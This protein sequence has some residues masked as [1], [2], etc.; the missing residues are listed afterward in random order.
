MTGSAEV[1]WTIYAIRK[2]ESVDWLLRSCTQLGSQKVSHMGYPHT[3]EKRQNVFWGVFPHVWEIYLLVTTLCK[4]NKIKK[5]VIFPKL[6]AKYKI[7]HASQQTA[8]GVYFPKWGHL[9]GGLC[10]LGILGP[11]KLWQVVQRWH[12]QFTPLE[13][14]GVLIGFRGPVHS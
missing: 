3:Q 5:I 10:Y 13:N 9:G 14:L 1:T 6:V 8:W 4:K 7:F 11:P 2:P 12:A